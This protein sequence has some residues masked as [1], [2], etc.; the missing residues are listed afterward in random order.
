MTMP[1]INTPF[2]EAIFWMDQS[3]AFFESA[4]ILA[5]NPSEYTSMPIITLQAFSVECSFK[6]LLLLTNGIYP[7]KHDSIYLF[8]ILPDPVKEDLSIQFFNNYDFV[9]KYALHEIR[10]DFIGSRYHF[11]DFKKSNVGRAFSTGYLET[12]TEF[13]IN[14]IRINGD[15]I[16]HTYGHSGSATGNPHVTLSTRLQ[17]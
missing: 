10:G 14:Y 6:A 1:R 15:G 16:S 5:N 7:E 13:L 11:E 17:S 12:I 2:D 3:S 4:K 8:E 9:L